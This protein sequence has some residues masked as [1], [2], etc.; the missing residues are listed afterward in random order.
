MQDAVRVRIEETP[1]PG[2]SQKSLEL[3]DDLSDQ[4]VF[5]I[6]FFFAKG[7]SPSSIKVVK[8]IPVYKTGF[9][10]TPD[11]YYGTTSV[12]TFN[13]LGHNQ[14]GFMAGKSTFTVTLELYSNIILEIEREEYA[15]GI[16]RDLSKAFDCIC[17]QLLIFLFRSGIR[18][19]PLK[20]IEIGSNM[21]H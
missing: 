4:L 3:T 18:G 17:H 12:C 8:V 10:H 14:Y 7:E 1:I 15:V 20:W 2:V 5:L 13:I 21:S 9:S 16:F 11:N 19:V 6:N